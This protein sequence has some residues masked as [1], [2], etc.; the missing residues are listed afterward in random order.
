MASGKGL[1]KIQG[2]AAADFIATPFGNNEF[3]RLL[4]TNQGSEEAEIVING[5]SD[6][7]AGNEQVEYIGESTL[8]VVDSAT[9]S[10]DGLLIIRAF[11]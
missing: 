8:F 3:S 10:A 2:I 6:N 9:A 5:E 7:L 4:V 11:A 1:F